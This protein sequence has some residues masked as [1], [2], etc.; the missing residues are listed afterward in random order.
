[1]IDSRMNLN[2]LFT[3]TVEKFMPGMKGA[4]IANYV[5]F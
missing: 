5:E 1:M 2:C 3:S 4:T